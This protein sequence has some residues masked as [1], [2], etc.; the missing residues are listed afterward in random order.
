ME[1]K[2]VYI[3]CPICGMQLINLGEPSGTYW[4]WCHDCK[5]E[6]DIELDKKESHDENLSCFPVLQ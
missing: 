2:L 3:N 4:Y 1:E 6:I 5:I